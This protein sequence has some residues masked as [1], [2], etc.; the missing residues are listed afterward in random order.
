MVIGSEGLAGLPQTVVPSGT[1]VVTT[2]PAPTTAF[3]P[4]STSGGI[5]EWAPIDARCLT[6]VLRSF[7]SPFTRGCLSFVKVTF[8]P[9]NTS[10]SIMTPLGIWTW[11]LIL[12]S[13]PKASQNPR[14]Q[15]RCGRRHKGSRSLRQFLNLQFSSHPSQATDCQAA[16]NFQCSSTQ[17][18][19]AVCLRKHTQGPL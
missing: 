14:H 7:Q 16:M 6:I 9:K 19:H 17:A 2:E 13:S 10:S 3:F 11:G 5:T 8:S 18:P 1:L 4:I 12:Q 15:V